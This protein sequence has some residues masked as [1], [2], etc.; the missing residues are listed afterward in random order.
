MLSRLE[1]EEFGDGILT[2][3]MPLSLHAVFSGLEILVRQEL[4]W[5]MYLLVAL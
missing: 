3:V 4:L 2:L 1:L 5:A